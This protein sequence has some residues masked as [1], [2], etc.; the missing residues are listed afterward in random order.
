M[1]VLVVSLA[2]GTLPDAERSPRAPLCAASGRLRCSRPPC[3]RLR[4]VSRV[5][6][7]VG[8]REEGGRL[9]SFGVGYTT[10]ALLRTLKP[11]GWHLS[12][13]CRGEEKAAALRSAGVEAHAWSPDDGVGLSSDGLLA[14]R[15]ATHVVT[16]VPPCGDLN[17]DPVLAL[18]GGELAGLASSSSSFRWLGYLSSTGV[19]GEHHGS[20][21]TE[22]SPLHLSADSD[23][24]SH[25]ARAE[26]EWLRLYERHQLPVHVFRLGGIYGPGR[27]MLDTVQR[28]GAPSAAQRLRVE[29]RYI[30]RCHVADI[31]SVLRASMATPRPGRVYNVV[32]DDPAPRSEVAAYARALL[33]GAEPAEPHSGAAATLSAPEEKRVRNQR[34]KEELSV[35]FR[36]P[37]YREGLRALNQGD[38]TPFA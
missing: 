35:T 30:S 25:R 13:A 37:S 1:A 36:Y 12:C 11:L 8:A 9:F 10:Q 14:L 17:C 3:S 26:A 20:W 23:K 4:C 6:A 21:V 2:L 7:A 19:Y 32:D 22:E 29:K 5:E 34:V 31:V 15:N 18:H 24:A 33:S 28:R 16:C 38:N 27:S